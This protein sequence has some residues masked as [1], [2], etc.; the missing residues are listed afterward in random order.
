MTS[1][2]P[3]LSVGIYSQGGQLGEHRCLPF[4]HRLIFQQESKIEAQEQKIEAQEQ[5]IGSQE[6]KINTLESI[7]EKF[8]PHLVRN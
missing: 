6:L 5:K 3:A 4:L 2:F 8:K 7:I 1:H